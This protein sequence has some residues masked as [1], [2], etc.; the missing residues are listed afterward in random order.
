[1]LLEYNCENST[2]KYVKRRSYLNVSFGV[3]FLQHHRKN[4]TLLRIVADKRHCF[5]KR[6]R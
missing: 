4:T 5:V 1:M 2:F 6:C 3:P